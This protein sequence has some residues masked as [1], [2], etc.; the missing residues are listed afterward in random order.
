M[1]RCRNNP[2]SRSR[3]ERCDDSIGKRALS[4]FERNHGAENL[5]LV[6]HN[7]HIG[8]KH[9]LDSQSDFIGG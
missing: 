8:L 1:S 3:A 9:A 6:F 7:E 5:I 2:L 4:F